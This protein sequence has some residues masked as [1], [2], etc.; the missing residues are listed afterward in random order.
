MAKKL[1]ETQFASFITS[2]MAMKPDF[3][4]ACLA[5]K[6]NVTF[7]EQAKPYGFFEKIPMWEVCRALLR[8]NHRGKDA[9]ERFC[10]NIK[11]FLSSPIWIFP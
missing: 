1:G 7:T 2:M 6:D 3:V 4:Y 5:S 11:G 9:S 8:V 10:S